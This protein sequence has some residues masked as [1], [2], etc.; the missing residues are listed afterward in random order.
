MD[1]ESMPL[2]QQGQKDKQAKGRESMITY[3]YYIVCTS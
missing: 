3:Y 2:D 1:Q